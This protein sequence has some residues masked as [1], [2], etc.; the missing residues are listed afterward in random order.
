MKSIVCRLLLLYKFHNLNGISHISWKSLTNEVLNA[1][2]FIYRH[3]SST[4]FHYN[5]RQWESLFSGLLIFLYPF[6]YSHNT[7]PI[8]NVSIL[9]ETASLRMCLFIPEVTQQRWAASEQPFLNDCLFTFIV[10]T[11]LKHLNL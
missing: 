5:A 8:C 3:I 2:L 1:L 7:P 10:P 6:K 11:R 9:N 4:S